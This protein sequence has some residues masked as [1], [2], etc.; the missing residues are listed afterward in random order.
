MLLQ[1]LASVVLVGVVLGFAQ[2]AAALTTYACPPLLTWAGINF[3]ILVRNVGTALTTFGPAIYDDKGNAPLY[4][5]PP[6]DVELKPGETF[7]VGSL[8][9]YFVPESNTASVVVR[10]PSGLTHS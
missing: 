5:R 9:E 4:S 10:S 1:R 6:T 2:G 3:S 7:I 8:S